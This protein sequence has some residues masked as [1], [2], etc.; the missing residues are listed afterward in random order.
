[1]VPADWIS[2]AHRFTMDRS[3]GGPAA[4]RAGMVVPE[5]VMR[6]RFKVLFFSALIATAGS[7]SASGVVDVSFADSQRFTDAGTTR[8]EED[9]NLQALASHFKKMGQRYLRD[10]ETLKVEVLDVDLAG[11]VR[12]SA[13]G[14][15]AIRV[16]R[17]GADW[18]RINLRYSLLR[19]GKPVR[20][21]TEVIADMNFSRNLAGARS[22]EPM[23]YE[24]AMIEKWFR[25]SLVEQHA[26]VN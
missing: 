12:Q 24:K 21:G 4:R 9:G 1:M 7:V 26:A 20:S 3:H 5:V 18:P 15:E 22:S 17:G 14:G 13:R 2:K 16:V 25:T 11:W 19:D 23:Q 8:W 6:H 10:G